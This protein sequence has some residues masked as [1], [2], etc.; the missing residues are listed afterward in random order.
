M[1]SIYYCVNIHCS[2][3]IEAIEKVNKAG[4]SFIPHGDGTSYGPF[5]FANRYD[6]IDLPNQSCRLLILSDLPATPFAAFP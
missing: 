4:R 6:G 3:I 5:V 1:I 2:D